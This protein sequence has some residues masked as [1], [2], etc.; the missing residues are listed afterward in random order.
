[1]VGFS[2]KSPWT[3]ARKAR[4]SEAEMPYLIWIVCFSFVQTNTNNQIQISVIIKHDL[5]ADSVP[6]CYA[7]RTATYRIWLLNIMGEKIHSD[8]L[9][10]NVGKK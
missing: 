3:C 2:R 5:S 9:E 7:S 10:K 4:N 1:M 6:I 8:F